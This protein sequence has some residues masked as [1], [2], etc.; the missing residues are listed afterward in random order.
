MICHMNSL[1]INPDSILIIILLMLFMN[2]TQKIAFDKLRVAFNN[3]YRRIFN[4]RWRCSVS[5]MY[6][7]FDINNFEATI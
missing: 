2:C 3:A 5:A 4:Q 1:D 7:N 6:A